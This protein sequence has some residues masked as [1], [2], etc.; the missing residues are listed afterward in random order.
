MYV[1]RTQIDGMRIAIRPPEYFPRLS[2]VALMRAVDVFVLADTFQYSRQSFQ[3][4][5]RLRTPDGWS[6]ISVPLLGRQHGKPIFDT[7][8]DNRS[9]WRSKHRRAFR[10]N[11]GNTAYFDFYEDQLKSLYTTSWTSLA[12]LTCATAELV[13]QLFGLRAKIVRASSLEATPSTLSAIV[14]LLKPSVLVVPSRIYDRD[15]KSCPEAVPFYFEEPVYRQH[16]DGFEEEITAMD[17]LCNYGPGARSILEAGF[18]E[19]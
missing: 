17:V 4:R 15:R 13:H 14:D 10:Y 2:F 5:T 7:R 9:S 19:N 16:F 18:I 12:S 1:R 8:V 3:N 6:W 11:Y